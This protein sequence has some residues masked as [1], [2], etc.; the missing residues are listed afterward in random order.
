MPTT[1]Y[2]FHH[3]SRLLESTC[4]SPPLGSQ[5]THSQKLNRFFLLE[6]D[7]HLPIQSPQVLDDDLNHS[8]LVLSGLQPL[9]WAVWRKLVIAHLSLE[10]R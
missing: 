6:I 10:Y 3:L 9:L 5:L 2:G 1:H 8:H 7:N 4:K